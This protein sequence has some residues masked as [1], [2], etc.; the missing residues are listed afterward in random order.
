MQ[1]LLSGL[2]RG[3]RGRRGSE[4]SEAVPEGAPSIAEFAFWF[5]HG[6]TFPQQIII[7]K[8]IHKIVLQ[9][10][11]DEEPDAISLGCPSLPSLKRHSK[12]IRRFVPS[13]KMNRKNLECSWQT[14]LSFE[15]KMIIH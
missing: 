3:L 15:L 9:S 4:A 7:C 10:I 2:V 5:R 1:S 13:Q 12:G 8:P 14:T 11:R 6:V